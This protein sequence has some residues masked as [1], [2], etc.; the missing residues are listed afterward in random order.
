MGATNTA[1][2]VKFMR[3][4]LFVAFAIALYLNEGGRVLLFA[5]LGLE[6]PWDLVIG[7]WCFISLWLMHPIASRIRHRSI[8][9]QP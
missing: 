3:G 6:F 9:C 1:D 5:I 4:M 2:I 8:R 7:V